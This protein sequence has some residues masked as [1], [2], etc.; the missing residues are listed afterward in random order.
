VDKANLSTVAS[1]EGSRYDTDTKPPSLLHIT[2]SS[3]VGN[4]LI[5]PIDDKYTSSSN[6]PTE[7]VLQFGEVSSSFSSCRPLVVLIHQLSFQQQD[8]NLLSSSE[9]TLDHP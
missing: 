5:L 9:L 8:N 7:G 1:T 2:R 6:A 3:S 4:L